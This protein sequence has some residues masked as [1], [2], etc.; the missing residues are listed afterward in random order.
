MVEPAEVG[1]AHCPTFK[2]CP[3]T[4]QLLADAK[5]LFVAGN[6]VSP[7]A[8]P[9][10]RLT[11]SA[12]EPIHNNYRSR[13]GGGRTREDDMSERFVPQMGDAPTD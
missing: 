7:P 1:G 2:F 12:A 13:I 10:G 8:I 11:D 3:E 4:D 5:A 6:K 9:N